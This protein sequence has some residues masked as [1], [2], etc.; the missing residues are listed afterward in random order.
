MKLITIFKS[1][2]RFIGR[3]NMFIILSI[4]YITIFGIAAI[5]VRPIRYFRKRRTKA[6]L[7]YWQEKTQTPTDRD[8]LL[9]QF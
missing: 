5:I 1:A 6:P 9:H 7:S 4:F 8:S 3:I 2:L